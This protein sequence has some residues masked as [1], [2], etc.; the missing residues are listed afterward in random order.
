M[1]ECVGLWASYREDVRVRRF[2][3]E[4]A[5]G[6]L[7]VVD[8]KSEELAQAPGVPVSHRDY[9]LYHAVEATNSYEQLVDLLGSPRCADLAVQ[10]HERLAGELK[11]RSGTR[12]KASLE[13]TGGTP[14]VTPRRKLTDGQVAR[15]DA[16]LLRKA[17]LS[18][19]A[20]NQQARG[21]MTEE[22]RPRKEFRQLRARQLHLQGASD[23]QIARR[24]GLSGHRAAQCL[25]E[26]GIR[27]VDTHAEATHRR[28]LYS[29]IVDATRRAMVS[30]YGRSRA[31]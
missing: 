11:Q 18:L 12:V 13:P 10:E 23:R 31:A 30:G 4:L 16:H 17:G 26:E 28:Q 2:A 27:V 20:A 5:S 21:P 6:R 15:Y 14:S 7:D 22:N 24:F 29:R 8:D 25:R 3:A 9:L 19:E 1:V